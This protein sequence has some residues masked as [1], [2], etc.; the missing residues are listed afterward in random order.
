MIQGNGL[1]INSVVMTE[2]TESVEIGYGIVVQ[3][4]KNRFRKV[5][6]G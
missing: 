2:F 1:K 5:V 6:R 4:R 3:F